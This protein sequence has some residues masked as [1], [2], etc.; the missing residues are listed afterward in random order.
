MQGRNRT[1]LGN[2]ALKQIA[3]DLIQS[4]FIYPHHSFK[5]TLVRGTNESWDLTVSCML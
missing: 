2:R 3:G 1:R 5:T 4:S